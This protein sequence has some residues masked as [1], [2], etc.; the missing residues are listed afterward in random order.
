[1]LATPELVTLVP[2]ILEQF[3]DN[4]EIDLSIIDD[5]L[6]ARPGKLRCVFGRTK[7]FSTA[8]WLEQHPLSKSKAID[9]ANICVF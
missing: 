9:N 7:S 1:M 4:N 5:C 8:N 3:I 2:I 6:Y